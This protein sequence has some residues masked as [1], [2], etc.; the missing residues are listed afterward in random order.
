VSLC[1]TLDIIVPVCGMLY[2]MPE[3]GRTT[4]EN[5]TMKPFDLESAKAGQKMLS[6]GGHTCTFVGFSRDGQV[7][8][9]SLHG[10]LI[11]SV[12]PENLKMIEEKKTYYVNVYRNIRLDKVSIGNAYTQK[13]KTDIGPEYEYIKTIE[14]E[15]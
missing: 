15:A 4:E 7:V 9:E 13:G 11:I 6:L 5:Q 1:G 12:R 2:P 10:G 8:A 3:F 14:F